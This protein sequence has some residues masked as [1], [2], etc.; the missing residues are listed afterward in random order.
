VYTVIYALYRKDGMSQEEFARHWTEVH[1][2]IART[3]PNV[4]SYRICPVTGSA[5]ALHEVD[6]FAVLDFD[7]EAD[8]GAAAQ[9]PEMAEAGEDAAKFARHFGVYMVDAHEVV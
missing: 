7:S 6:G 2:P 4:R 5:D 9:S 8:F 1:A 3:L